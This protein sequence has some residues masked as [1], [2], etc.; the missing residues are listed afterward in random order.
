MG[1][2]KEKHLLQQENKA[3]NERLI[4]TVPHSDLT[5][6]NTN[7][8]TDTYTDTDEYWVNIEQNTELN[9]EPNS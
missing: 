8:D 6:T 9:I 2:T 3:N 5:D 7:T 1:S 4:W